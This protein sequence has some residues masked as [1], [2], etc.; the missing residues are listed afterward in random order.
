MNIITKHPYV[1]TGFMFGLVFIAGHILSYDDP[2]EALMWFGVIGAV[3]TTFC[4][5]VDHTNNDY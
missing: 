2:A 4:G 5:V 1:F 3:A